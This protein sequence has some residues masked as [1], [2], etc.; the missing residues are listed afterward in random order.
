MRKSMF[1]LLVLLGM[2]SVA[3]AWTINI[4][5]PAS[6]VRLQLNDGTV[7]ANG[8]NT[9][10]AGTYTV[11]ANDNSDGGNCGQF[12]VDGSGHVSV[13]GGAPGMSAT[14]TDNN[15]T[16]NVASFTLTQGTYSG[17]Y[18]W[19]WINAAIYGNTT[20]NIPL[21]MS[22][23]QL[24]WATIDAAH[25]FKV[26]TDASGN[27]S[28][29][30]PAAGIYPFSVAGGTVTFNAGCPAV[31]FTADGVGYVLNYISG[32][33]GSTNITYHMMPGPWT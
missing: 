32:Y 18:Y 21:G 20:K 22:N 25:L 16:V 8:A 33:V 9:L 15:L 26:S 7:L 23:M 30:S 4:T 27:A 24:W 31:Q 6:T 28:V 19:P 1:V 29:V 11:Y 5:I 17:S 2:S 13:V 14:G 10:N 12:T 3:S